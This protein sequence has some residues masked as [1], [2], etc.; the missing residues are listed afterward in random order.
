[1]MLRVLNI[2]DDDDND[3]DD[4]DDCFV[5]LSMDLAKPVD[6]WWEDR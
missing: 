2:N 1:M 6:F 4:D 3:D 5:S